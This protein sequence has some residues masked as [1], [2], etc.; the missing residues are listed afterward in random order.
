[1][2]R[3][4]SQLS[5]RLAGRTGTSRAAAKAAM[6]GVFEV[7]CTHLPRWRSVGVEIP[8]EHTRKAQP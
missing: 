6:D 1:M 5:E 3:N 4:K 7:I 2:W 8:V